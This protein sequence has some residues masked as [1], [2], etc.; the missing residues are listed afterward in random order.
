MDMRVYALL[1]AP[2]AGVVV[3]VTA[4][5]A[6]RVVAVSDVAPSVIAKQLT[7]VWEQM[8]PRAVCIGLV[9]SVRS[10][11]IVRRFLQKLKP[12]P[13]IVI[14]PVIA[15]TSGDRFL[16]TAHIRELQKL[17]SIATVVTPNI[18]E[19][20]LLT[21]RPVA[22]LAQAK[23]A[24]RTISKHGCA[25]LVTGGHLGTQ[26]CT[27]VLA[28]STGVQQYTVPRL[29]RSMRGAGGILAAALTV[30]LSRG[31]PLTRAVARAR[32]FVRRVLAR[33]GYA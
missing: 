28:D 20:G 14:D 17:L 11:Q 13:A 29:R 32:Q 9:P 27:D 10:L 5:N 2:C 4:Q 7:L 1:R 18:F 8:Q 23:A 19:A 16:G 15:A 22:N 30:E 3:A 6:K 26:R 24:A 33:A 31:V 12:R 21:S 25:T